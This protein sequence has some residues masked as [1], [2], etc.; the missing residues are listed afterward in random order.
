MSAAPNWRTHNAASLK[1]SCPTVTG[2]PAGARASAVVYSLVETAKAN[3]LEPYTWLS[4]V[5]TYQPLA[6]S[7]DEIEALMPWNLH[8]DRLAFEQ[9]A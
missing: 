4:H 3:G 7:V 5:L 9:I 2:T 6:K 1:S 8:P